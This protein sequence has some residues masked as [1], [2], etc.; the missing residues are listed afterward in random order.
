[1]QKALSEATAGAANYR[2]SVV[3]PKENRSQSTTLSRK[4][5]WEKTLVDTDNTPASESSDARN[6]CQ[7]T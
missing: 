7:Q 6:P 1:M 3:F 2:M 4:F 5:T